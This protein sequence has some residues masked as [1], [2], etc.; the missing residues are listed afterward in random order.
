MDGLNHRH[1][2]GAALRTAYDAMMD[3]IAIGIALSSTWSKPK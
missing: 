3:D 1:S 2:L